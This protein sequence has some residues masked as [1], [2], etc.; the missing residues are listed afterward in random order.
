MINFLHKIV[1]DPVI[2]DPFAQP[3]RFH[4]GTKG[5]MM[6]KGTGRQSKRLLPWRYG[7][8]LLAFASTIPAGI[9]TD[10]PKGLMIG[11]DLAALAFMA[12]LVPLFAH[13][14]SRIRVN[15]REND[16]N[17]TLI[18]LITAIVSAVVLV[19]VA[20]ELGQRQA[21]NALGI[22]LVLATLSI[23]WL[24]SNLVYTLHY[25]FL[26]YAEDKDAKGAK[27]D[28]GGLDIP[29]VREPDYWDFAYFAFTLGMTFQTS[30][31]AVTHR[32][33]RKVVLAN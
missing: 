5:R 24:F 8:F 10:F 29:N 23:A 26:F 31:V 13:D 30:D 19:A 7:L 14:G 4:A 12:S 20:L 9:L 25:A 1:C 28:R 32:A 17:R 3:F 33:I 15:A 21:S 22:T 2:N 18:L 11:F 27:G 6:V 16:A